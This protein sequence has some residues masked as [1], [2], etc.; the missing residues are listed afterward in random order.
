MSGWPTA[1]VTLMPTREL[2]APAPFDLRRTV[3][4]LGM[5]ASGQSKASGSE[6][7][8]AART[9]QGP[10]TVR[11]ALAAGV[12]SAESWGPGADWMLAHV[13]DFLGMQDRPEEFRPRPGLIRELH[14]RNRG[15]RIGRTAR[16]FEALVPI[17]L[18]QR[19]TNREARL[20]GFRLARRY[21]EPAPGPTDL[22]LLPGPD[23]VASLSY[24][25]LHPLGIE[26]KRAAVLVEVA[27]RSKRLEE[28]VG[29]SRDDAY[30][31]LSNVRGLGSWTAGHVMGIAWGDPDAVPVGDFHLP[32]TVSFALAGEDRGNDERMLQL[33]R[34]Y[35]GHRRRVV[36][37]LK[38]AGMKA[39]KYGPR[40]ATRSI[41]HI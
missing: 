4:A 12:V 24:W 32:N 22:W 11:I 40:H 33:L 36:L 25:E 7:W 30:R 35:A 26:R 3:A 9:P 27:R 29:M 18:G 41:E 8:W 16:V 39:P 2:A 38:G 21:G 20:A 14:R 5:K 17:V 19:V 23:T 10:G 37:L 28:I 31:R 15:L 1:T 13:P 34:P 6:A